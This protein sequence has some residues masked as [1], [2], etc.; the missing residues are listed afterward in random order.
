MSASRGIVPES[1]ETAAQYHVGVAAKCAA[2]V[3]ETHPSMHRDI[4]RYFAEHAAKVSEAIQVST[5]GPGAPPDWVSAA[6]TGM[7]DAW[8]DLSRALRGVGA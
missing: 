5:E 4:V 3:T 2:R 6:A 1:A 7:R 8:D